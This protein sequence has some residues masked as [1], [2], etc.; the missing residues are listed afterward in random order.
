VSFRKVL[1]ARCQHSHALPLN[2]CLWGCISRRLRLRITHHHNA[3]SEGGRFRK[4]PA[5]GPR[6]HTD[7]GV[8]PGADRRLLW[9]PMEEAESVVHIHSLPVRRSGSG[10]PQPPATCLVGSSLTA[11][12]NL[13][14]SASGARQL[15][16]TGLILPQGCLRRPWAP[17]GRVCREIQTRAL[18]PNGSSAAESDSAGT[19]FARKNR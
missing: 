6:P 18:R 15:P 4:L 9:E 14:R 16:A 10:Q 19:S 13:R 11:L 2:E 12:R 3:L 8:R 1:A 5:A 17:Q 7:H